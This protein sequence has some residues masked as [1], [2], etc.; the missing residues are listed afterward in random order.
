MNYANYLQSPEWDALRKKAYQ[1]AKHKCELC[2]D[3]A[4]HVHHIKYP[5]N[6]ANDETDNLIV[7][8]ED[9]HKKLHGIR[10]VYIPDDVWVKAIAA[11]KQE[12]ENINKRFYL[13]LC[14][15]EGH[16]LFECDYSCYTD[17]S[18][19][20]GWYGNVAIDNH[21]FVC[22]IDREQ[23]TKQPPNLCRYVQS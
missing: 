15:D 14:K 22:C 13:I 11:G 12:M 4:A 17:G 16:T 23:A 21:L 20:G 19:C 10:E 18:I 7:V 2:A 8:C 6:L 9:C 1:R 5:K 3:S